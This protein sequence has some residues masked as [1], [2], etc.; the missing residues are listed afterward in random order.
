M[1]CIYGA[2]GPL[3]EWRPVMRRVFFCLAILAI[4]AYAVVHYL[5]QR[6]EQ[7]VAVADKGHYLIVRP[8][9]RLKDVAR[10]LYEEEVLADPYLLVAFGR[11]T[12]LDEKIK[13]G[14]YIIPRGTTPAELLRLLSQGAV[15]QY[16]VTLPEGITLADA[17]EILAQQAELKSV[18]AG[19]Q[20]P[21]ISA[22]TKPHKLAEGLFFPDSYRYEK[23]TSDWQILQR[24]YQR[25]QKVLVFEWQQKA[26]DLP[27]ETPYEALIMASIV[28]RETGVPDERKQIA[29][30]FVRR[31]QKRMRLQ[32]DPVVIYGLGSQFDGN[33]RRK[34]LQD[35]SNLY[36]TYRH[37]GLPPGPI[38]LPGRAAINAALHPDDSPALYF[39]ARGDGSHTF[40]K[41]LAQHQAAVK[42]YQL[43]RR[44]DYRSS[45]E[46]N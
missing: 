36:N 31:L 25:M 14:E 6:W 5:Q 11:W 38:S 28:E 26:A 15:I 42:K 39:V 10:Q 3:L 45:P 1:A 18:L 2:S 8:G 20:D 44:K 41:T 13:R 7:P 9:A 43:T 37:S 19:P 22:L 29:G 46:R 40:S 12:G 21:R 24:A 16:Q 33:L 35:K 32:T 30:V 23:G 34:H 17:L 27:Y 4:G